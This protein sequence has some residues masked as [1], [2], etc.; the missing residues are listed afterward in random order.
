MERGTV[1]MGPTMSEEID[2]VRRKLLKTP[3]ELSDGRVVDMYPVHPSSDVTGWSATGNGIMYLQQFNVNGVG[4]ARA[5]LGWIV[6]SKAFEAQQ[7]IP[8][9]LTEWRLRLEDKNATGG[10]YAW[11]RRSV[12]S[13]FD[14]ELGAGFCLAL[15]SDLDTMIVSVTA[16]DCFIQYLNALEYTVAQIVERNGSMPAEIL[17]SKLLTIL[18]RFKTIYRSKNGMPKNTDRNEGDFKDSLV[19]FAS[20]LLHRDVVIASIPKSSDGSLC[21]NILQ[22]DVLKCSSYAAFKAIVRRRAED[23]LYV[24]R[25]SSTKVMSP[26]LTSGGNAHAADD[27]PDD[28]EHA[29]PTRPQRQ[30]PNAATFDAGPPRLRHN[31]P[32]RKLQN[33]PT[34][35]MPS[36][37][38]PVPG[39]REHPNRLPV[40]TRQVFMS[41]SSRMSPEVKKLLR[42]IYRNSFRED[43]LTLPE[44]LAKLKTCNELAWNRIRSDKALLAELELPEDLSGEQLSELMQCANKVEEALES[45]IHSTIEKHYGRKIDELEHQHVASALAALGQDFR[46]GNPP[47]PEAEPN[48][49]A[50]E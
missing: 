30:M 18:T 14:Q 20:S 11:F 38:P 17:N 35:G 2:E 19:D 43:D 39:K 31:E 4:L 9:E 27:A 41:S 46:M 47:N 21:P 29:H 15:M 12:I 24:Q 3:L 25:G 13:R 8:V 42:E 28:G 50:K 16:S 22:S 6:A 23:T 44:A 32:P 45:A 37:A 49:E 1:S 40:A 10:V 26:T 7:D 48:L 34:G 5:A 33:L 36:R